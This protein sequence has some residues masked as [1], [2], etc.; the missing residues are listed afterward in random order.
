MAEAVDDHACQRGGEA[1]FNQDSLSAVHTELFFGIQATVAV[2]GIF[3]HNAGEIGEENFLHFIHP[4]VGQAVSLAVGDEVIVF[5][6]PKQGIG[7]GGIDTL[8]VVL[9]QIDA[10]VEIAETNLTVGFYGLVED[11]YIGNTVIL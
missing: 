8:T 5:V 10:P 6:V 7:A 1:H 11:V 4:I 2:F 9:L 3:R